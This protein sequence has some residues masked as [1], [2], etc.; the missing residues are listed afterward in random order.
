MF[1]FDDYTEHLNIDKNGLDEE[2]LKQPI[3]YEHYSTEWAEAVNKRDRLKQKLDNYKA[4]LEKKVRRKLAKKSKVTEKM[5]ENAVLTD[6]KYQKK[7]DRYLKAKGKANK[8]G[9]RREA[10]AQKKDMLKILTDLFIGNYY[11]E[12]RS[13]AQVE[14]GREGVK[15]ALRKK[16]KK[17]K[18]R[19]E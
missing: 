4:G 19:K 1:S 8:L 16:K 17:K 6:K 7:V 15:L 18:G 5:I 11:G 14:L 2:C 9:V 10:F 13:S 3:L 12:V